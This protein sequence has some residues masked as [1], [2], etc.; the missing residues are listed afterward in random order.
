M[1]SRPPW[2]VWARKGCAGCPANDTGLQQPLALLAQAVKVPVK[3]TVEG[4]TTVTSCAPPPVS[5]T[6]FGSMP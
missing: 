3:L 5:A 1:G 4:S 2:P 6:R